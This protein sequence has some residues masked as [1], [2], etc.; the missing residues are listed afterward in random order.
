[1]SQGSALLRLFRS[2]VS[3]SRGSSG[4]FLAKALIFQLFSVGMTFLVSFVLT[5]DMNTSLLISGYDIVLKVI[6]YYVFDVSWFKLF[7]HL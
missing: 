2:R 6:L 1:M 7:N 5:R 4:M 3:R